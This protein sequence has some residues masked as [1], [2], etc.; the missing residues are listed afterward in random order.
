[1]RFEGHAPYVI[2]HDGMPCEP[3][4]AAARRGSS[5]APGMRADLVLDAAAEPG[6]VFGVIDDFFANDTYEVLELAY[7]SGRFAAPRRRAA[8]PI[9]CG[10]R[11]TPCRGPIPTRRAGMR[12]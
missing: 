2:A 11:P 12:W 5:S 3:Y 8:P 7:A 9:A 1:M 10:C 4:A 6:S